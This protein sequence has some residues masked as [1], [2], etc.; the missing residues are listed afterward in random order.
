MG[1]FAEIVDEQWKANSVAT[2]NRNEDNSSRQTLFGEN[3][4]A[5]LEKETLVASIAAIHHHD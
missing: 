3:I 5:S 2:N 4:F 1:T